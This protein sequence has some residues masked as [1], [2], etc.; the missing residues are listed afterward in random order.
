MTI[1]ADSPLGLYRA[2]RHAG[3]LRPDSAQELAIEKLQLLYGRLKHHGPRQVSRWQ[4]LLR[5][6]R[7]EEPLKGLYFVGDVG[8]G[9]TMVM[10][11][12]FETA[13]V[14]AKRRTH[15]HAFM[16][17]AHERINRFRR[18]FRPSGSDPVLASA[19]EI[20]G[21]A[22]LLCFDEMEVRD[23]ADAMILSRLFTQLFEHGVVV[24]AT[25]NRA[26]DDLYQGGLNRELFLPFIDTIKE[27]M[28]VVE[29]GGHTDY[30]LN[31]IVGKPVYHTP[32]GQTADRALAE[33]FVQLTDA[34][35]GDPSEIEIKGRKIAVSEQAKGVARFTFQDLC[36]RPLAAADYLAISEHYHTVIL[37]NIPSLGPEKRNEARRLANLID[38]LYDNRIKLVCSA[39]AAPAELYPHGDGT[40]EFSRT[41][42]RL[43]EMQSESYVSAP[44]PDRFNAIRA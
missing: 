31:R 9:K 33:A 37:A 38:V 34:E 4:E 29:L 11:L 2:K 19:E 8:R 44:H 25:S 21:Q 26:P 27:K 12:F 5:L 17:D 23:V 16:R 3:E 35:R 24:V 30:R 32:L 39:A 14:M 7:R 13:P 18:D 42:S 20:A 6:K 36:E 40:F 1:P 10:D 28:E 41:V 43:T 22:W 15:F